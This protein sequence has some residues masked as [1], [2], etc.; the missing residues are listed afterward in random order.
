[1][2]EIIGEFEG[3]FGVWFDSLHDF[4]CDL[5]EVAAELGV[6]HENHVVA[7]GNQHIDN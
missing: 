1:M 4:Y 7:L 2:E 3:L 5:L 6:I